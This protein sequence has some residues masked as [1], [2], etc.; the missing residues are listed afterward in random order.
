MIKSFIMFRSPLPNSLPETGKHVFFFQRLLCW[1]KVVSPFPSLGFT[2]IPP[3]M[4]SC[5]PNIIMHTWDNMFAI[6]LVLLYRSVVKGDLPGTPN[7]GYPLWQASHTI[8][9]SLGILM[10]VGL[11]NSME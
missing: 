7:N 3:R 11:G 5:Y 1:K 4:D 6:L 10:G 8:P 9:I 2:L